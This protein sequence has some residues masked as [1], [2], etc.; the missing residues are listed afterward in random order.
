[1]FGVLWH[2]VSTH[3]GGFLRRF[4]GRRTLVEI[5]IFRY[6]VADAMENGQMSQ[7]WNDFINGKATISDVLTEYGTL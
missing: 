6:K 2:R 5:L 3:S 7:L 1:M 4:N